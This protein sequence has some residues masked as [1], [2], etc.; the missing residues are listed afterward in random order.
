MKLAIVLPV[1]DEADHV[2][3]RLQALASL[4]ARGVRVVV[5]DGGSS[6]DTAAQALRLAPMSSCS[7]TPIRGCPSRPMNS[8]G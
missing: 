3:P 7:C 4:R 6:D 8:S 2:V 5:V 1:L